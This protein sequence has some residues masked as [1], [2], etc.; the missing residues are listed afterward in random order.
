MGLSKSKF[1]AGSQYLKRLCVEVHLPGQLGEPDERTMA[2]FEQGYEV[3]R[4]P[5]KRFPGGVFMDAEPA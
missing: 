3:G 5:Q 1:M 4:L 2:V